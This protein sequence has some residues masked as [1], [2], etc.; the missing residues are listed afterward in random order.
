ML[1][2]RKFVFNPFGEN[3]Y[4]V[5]DNAT[6]ETAVI[7]PGMLSAREKSFF[8]DYIEKE[9][10]KLT[11]IINTHL[12]VDHCLGNN[13]VKEKFGASTAASAADA[14]L[15]LQVAQQARQFGMPFDD[16]RPVTID[17]NL[18]DGDII[19]IGESEL[20]V[21]TVP[22]HSP[23]GLALYSPEDKFLISGDSLFH[24]SIGRTDLPGGSHADLIRNVKEK[25]LT[26]P[27]DTLVLPG[28]DNPT[29]IAD[30][31]ASNPFLK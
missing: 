30:E 20:K 13:Y 16:E 18:K 11:Q 27:P 2:V 6:R 28:H 14:P 21:I 26:L 24:G 31:K 7:D 19:K 22:G 3:T 29:T 5:I 10:L 25:L 9:G 8:E 12:H 15:G 17:R 4:L 23:G 1:K